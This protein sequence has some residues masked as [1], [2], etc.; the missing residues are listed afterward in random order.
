MEHNDDEKHEHHILPDNISLRILISLLVLTVVTVAA[1]RINFGAMNFPIALA[2]ASLKAL[3]V[4]LFFMGIKYDDRENKVIFFSSI[5]FV[6]VFFLLTAADIFARRS[7]WRAHGP[8]LK[9]VSAASTVKKPWISTE[10]LKTR[11]K[12]IFNTQCVVC[13]GPNGKGDGAAAAALNPKP[14]N[15]TEAA[16]WKNGRKVTDVFTTLKN[17][18]NAMPSFAT[19]STDDRWALTHYVLSLGPTPADLEAGDFKKVGITDPTKDDGG[20]GGAESAQ[21]KIPVGFAIERYLKTSK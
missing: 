13:H 6:L 20:M 10:D 14:R 21:R 12:E 18:L 2:I 9:E 15:F 4:V 19:L 8:I 3:L 5:F 16:G 7:D 17:G 1:S 11:G